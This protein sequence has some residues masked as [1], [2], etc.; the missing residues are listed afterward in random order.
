MQLWKMTNMGTEASPV[1]KF[2][3]TDPRVAADGKSL[4]YTDGAE[5]LW[6]AGFD[7]QTAAEIPGLEHCRF[8]R[9]WF[10]SDRGI[11]YVNID[12]DRSKLMLY[13]FRTKVSRPVLTLP[14]DPLMGYP[15]LS[16]SAG[17][18]SILFASKEDPRSDLVMVGLSR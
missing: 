17:S 6:Q 16:Y 1:L 10:V 4:F 18:N 7:G 9:L 12:S 2:A 5:G 11:Y 13:D 3:V 15:S 8:G 14:R